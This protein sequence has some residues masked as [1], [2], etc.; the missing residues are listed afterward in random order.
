MRG[1]IVSVN[2]KWTGDVALRLEGE[3]SKKAISDALEYILQESNKIVPHDEGTLQRSGDIDVEETSSGTSG[4]VYYD[5][6]YA[7]RLHEHPEYNFQDGRQGKYLEK[8]VNRERATVLD[9]LA[10]EYRDA[11]K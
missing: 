8:T 5:T 11:F 6:P 7:V 4:S 10:K 3:A 1:D 9:Y 2:I